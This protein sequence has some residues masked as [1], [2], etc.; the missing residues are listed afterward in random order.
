VG[1]ASA[2][3]SAQGAQPEVRVAEP[4]ITEM[5]AMPREQAAAAARAIQRIGSD[6]GVALRIPPPGIPDG[7][8]LAIVPDDPEAPVVIYR[9]LTQAEG[10]GYLVTALADRDTYDAYEHAEQNGHLDSPLWK[11]LA[12]VAVAAAVGAVNARGQ[13]GPDGRPL[14]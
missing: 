13:V 8:Y 14:K 9:E 5:R 1:T 2:A 3:A 12:A 7:H 4:V 10:G 6:A 11:T